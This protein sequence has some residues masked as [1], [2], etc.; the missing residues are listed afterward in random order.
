LFWLK[1][2]FMPINMWKT[3]SKRFKKQRSF[4]K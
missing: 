1:V 2:F 4:E 3:T